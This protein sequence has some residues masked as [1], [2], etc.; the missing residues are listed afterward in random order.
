MLSLID[1]E[2]I[3][4]LVRLAN[5]YP[6]K[7][8]LHEGAWSTDAERLVEGISPDTLYLAMPPEE[9][10][11][12]RLSKTSNGFV[13]KSVTSLFSRTGGDIEYY[14]ASLSSESGKVCPEHLRPLWQNI[15]TLDKRFVSSTT[16]DAFAEQQGETFNWLMLS[17]LS[18]VDVLNGAKRQLAVVDVVIART[19][20]DPESVPEAK[21]YA[22]PTLDVLMKDQ[23]FKE[24]LL[25]SERQPKVGRVVYVRDWKSSLQ[26][27]LVRVQWEATEECGKLS[28]ELAKTRGEL[29]QISANL[30]EVISEKDGLSEDCAQRNAKI[31]ELDGK[32]SQVSDD[33]ANSRAENEQL[34]QDIAQLQGQIDQLGQEQAITSSDLAEAR[35][36]K[37]RLLDQVGQLNANISMIQQQLD[38]RLLDEAEQKQ[39][40]ETLERSNAQLLANFEE[41]PALKKSLDQLQAE[42]SVEFQKAE[43]AQQR[44]QLAEHNLE[45]LRARY[46]KLATENETLSNRLAQ[47]RDQ[48]RA[49]KAALPKIVQSGSGRSTATKKTRATD[50]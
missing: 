19:I 16:I 46:T 27:E 30:A 49:A 2:D 34:L 33:L 45:N 3:A 47:I 13:V 31:E 32:L 24:F 14:E 28:V 18:A 42:K 15:S 20:I 9:N 50:V 38:Q 48:L 1:N 21:N 40:I 11:K 29:G 4:N 22:K 44:Q 7:S 8:L 23:G 25:I 26:S 6:P 43:E 41:V 17:G 37:D 12:L 5:F 39:K 35:S 10:S 36:E